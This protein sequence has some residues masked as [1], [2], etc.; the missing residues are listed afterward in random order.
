MYGICGKAI[1][2]CVW[3]VYNISV[4]HT[5]SARK[6]ASPGKRWLPEMAEEK[7][8]VDAAEEEESA[9]I[10]LVDED[11]AEFEFDILAS[12]EQDGVTY[13]AVIAS[14]EEIGD[15]GVV[16]YGIIKSALDEN[17]EEIFVSLDDDDEAYDDIADRFDDILSEEIDYD[18]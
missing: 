15:D 12:Y 2:K 18:E 11:G 14:D 17:G 10:T 9:T 1:D 3:V 13:L 6:D 16:E 5:R 8:T 4:K 7:K